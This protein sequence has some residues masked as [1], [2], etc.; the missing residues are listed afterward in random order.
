[1]SWIL[2]MIYISKLLSLRCCCLYFKPNL[3]LL[4]FFFVKSYCTCQLL[5]STLA[6]FKILQLCLFIYTIVHVVSVVRSHQFREGH[7]KYSVYNSEGCA[8]EGTLC[9]LC[10][11]FMV[12]IKHLQEL[13]DHE[14]CYINKINWYLTRPSPYQIV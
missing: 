11:S 2:A 8:I 4:L 10:T 9:V 5:I 14:Q 3:P 12:I 6:R 13:N 7:N 1:M